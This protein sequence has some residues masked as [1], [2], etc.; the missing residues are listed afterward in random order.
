[1][2][3]AYDKHPNKTV[4]TKAITAFLSLI[5]TL[6]DFIFNLAKYIQKMG[7]AHFIFKLG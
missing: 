1:M 3:E 4:S 6:N 5:F 2:K 7:C